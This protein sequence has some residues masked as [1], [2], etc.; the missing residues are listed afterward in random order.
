MY[1]FDIDGT[2]LLTGGSGTI[3]INQLFEERYG[4]SGAMNSVAAGGKTDGMIF[5]E[6]AR[7]SMERDLA[8]EEVSELIA[9]Y[10][11]M[12]EAELERAPRFRL[13][14]Y[15]RECMAFVAE[16][17]DIVGIATGNVEGAAN[18]KLNRADLRD[19]FHFGGYGSDSPIRPELVATAM[20]RGRECAARNLPDEDFVVIGDT[21][22]DITA[23]RACG[24]RVIAVATGSVSKETLAG[25]EP[26]ALFDTLE[27][28][29][30]WHH[31]H[32]SLDSGR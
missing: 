14:P 19:F 16:V 21:L 24:A 3:A 20:K 8:E 4:V 23:A 28:L 15:V 13:M 31:Q 7:N 29:P 17:Q 30:S 5:Q 25:A 18:A 6:C 22:H 11:P 12:L 1:L 27:E 10:L 26:D 2:L 32:F 9:A